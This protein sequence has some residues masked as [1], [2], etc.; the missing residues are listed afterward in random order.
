MSIRKSV[1]FKNDTKEE[2]L[3][4]VK[5]Q[6]NFSDAIT[7][8]IE[9]EIFENG[10]RDLSKFI[11]SVRTNEYFENIL[12]TKRISIGFNSYD[13]IVELDKEKIEN[14]LNAVNSDENN[15]VISETKEN[16]ID[17]DDF[18]IS[19]IEEIPDCYKEF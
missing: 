4:F 15:Q 14:S 17:N 11:P 9:K 7:Y 18:G 10:I 1:K 6:S 3:K 13:N 19:D 2:V 16:E 5:M 8:L 12:N